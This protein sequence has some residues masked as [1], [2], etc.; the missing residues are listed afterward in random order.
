MI[1]EMENARSEIRMICKNQSPAWYIAILLKTSGSAL[2]TPCAGA[3]RSAGT[4]GSRL[5]FFF[6]C[7]LAS[8]D[9]QSCRSRSIT[10]PVETAYEDDLVVGA[11]AWSHAQTL[12]LFSALN[13]VSA[14]EQ[15]IQRNGKHSRIILGRKSYYGFSVFFLLLTSNELQ[16]DYILTCSVSE[17]PVKSETLPATWLATVAKPKTKKL[18]RYA[19]WLPW[20]CPIH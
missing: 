14:E 16:S 9:S 7:W 1:F 4:S 13:S 19:I 3:C 10:S 6:R 11:E 2:A 20:Y 12:K 18:L 5:R 15:D 8:T 17:F